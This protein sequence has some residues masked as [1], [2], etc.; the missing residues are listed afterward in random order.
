MASQRRVTK[1][2]QSHASK[3]TVQAKQPMKVSDFTLHI[4]HFIL[5][6]SHEIVLKR[7]QCV[8]NNQFSDNS[9]SSVYTSRLEL[10]HTSHVALH[11]LTHFTPKSLHS[12]LNT[13]VAN[14]RHSHVILTIWN[15]H[16]LSQ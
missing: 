10:L 14:V 16:I 2:R 11:V 1:H 12:A 3:N 9:K 4:L 7:F 5:H 15:T 8:Q 13:R 6:T